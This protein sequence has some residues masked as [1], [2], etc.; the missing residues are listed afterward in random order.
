MFVLRKR[1]QSQIM[2]VGESFTVAHNPMPSSS[3][4]FLLCFFLHAGCLSQNEKYTTSTAVR[5]R[6]KLK[7]L[8]WGNVLIWTI[9]A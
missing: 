2:K 4:S 8:K 1:I 6:S 5:K 7:L 3:S 9:V